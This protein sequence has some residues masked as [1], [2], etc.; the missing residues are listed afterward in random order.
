MKTNAAALEIIKRNEGLRLDAYLDVVGVPTI[1]YGHTGPDVHL[2]MTISEAKA[3][4]LLAAR[5]EREFEPG[6]LRVIGDA[7]TTDN[8]FGAMVS[9]AYNIGVGAFAGSTV[10]RMHRAG[11]W[12]DAAEAFALWNKAGGREMAGLTR[13][14]MEEATLYLNTRNETPVVPSAPSAITPRDSIKALQVVLRDAGYYRAAIDG[15]FGPRS[16]AALSD[17]LAAAGQARL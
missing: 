5:L 1:G 10:V 13:R 17:L 6:V 11:R 4:Q 12:Q 2:G 15:D 9:L 16:R 3:E 7:P 14:R 8:Q